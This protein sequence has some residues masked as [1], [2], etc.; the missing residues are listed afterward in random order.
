MM[1]TK[2]LISISVMLSLILISCKNELT[3]LNGIATYGIGDTITLR[4]GDTAFIRNEN[5]SITFNRLVSD[6]RCPRGVECIWAGEAIGE[7]QFTKG[8]LSVRFNSSTIRGYIAVDNYQVKLTDVLPYPDIHNPQP[9]NYIAKIVV[10]KLDAALVK[11]TVKDYT[12]LDGCGLIIVLDDG[13]KLEPFNANSFRLTNNER[14][15]LSYTPLSDVVT[16]CMV[17]QPVQIDD[18]YELAE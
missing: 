1:K 17:G 3:D 13:K 18:L 16:I 15:L 12:G 5:I 2:S 8:N 6:S 7:I 9:D 11:G 10:K 4:K 14:I